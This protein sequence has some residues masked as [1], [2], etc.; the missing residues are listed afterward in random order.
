MNVDEKRKLVSSYRYWRYEIDFGDDIHA[1]SEYPMITEEQQKE[2][3]HKWN[4]PKDF[5][6]DKDVLDI[7]AWDGIYSFLAERQGAASVVALDGY[8]WNGGEVVY[9]KRGFDIIKQLLDSKVKDVTMDIM[10]ATPD[11]LGTFDTILF[12]GVLYHL[13]NPML[14]LQTIRK[15]MRPNGRILLDT[16][17]SRELKLCP[18]PA[19]QYH[20]NRSL[21]DDNS[22]WWTA[23]V[24][25][26]KEMLI[27]CGFEVERDFERSFYEDRHSFYCRAI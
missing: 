22:N 18:F 19:M 12:T 2:R 9:S 13:Q 21:A 20:P 15:L 25:C 16:L 17:I 4:Y 24:S 23:N 10:D 26:I 1:K 3:L 8:I 7:G 27:E 5:F 6:K 11:N 14:A